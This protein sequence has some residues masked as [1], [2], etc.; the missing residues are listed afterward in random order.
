MYGDTLDFESDSEL[1][2]ADS[3][4][5]WQYGESSKTTFAPFKG[6]VTDTI[7]PYGLGENDHLYLS[8][9]ASQDGPSAVFVLFQHKLD[10]Q[11]A[12]EGA[13]VE[14]SCDSMNWNKVEDTP[15]EVINFYNYPTNQ[16]QST[17][18]DS[19]NMFTGTFN[20]W[21]WSGFQ[22][23]WYLPV[24]QGEENRGADECTWSDYLDG[25]LHV[26]FTFQSDDVETTQAGWMIRQVVVGRM[27]FW[28]SV[29]ETNYHPLTI[30][31]NPT[32]STISIQLP[33]N[34]LKATHTRIYDM[35]GRLVHQHP[36]NPNMDVSH[37]DSG[38]YIVVVETEE[39]NFRGTIQ[40]E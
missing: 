31:P 7:D 24:F 21:K 13:F 26:R 3:G 38:T 22:L 16:Q 19:G 40:K 12:N 11:A 32:T 33:E 29:S 27:D 1:F 10:I 14:V 8:I 30:Y 37:L 25:K 5:L 4:G 34:N 2:A 15:C 18:F 39:G 6:W 23:I 20:E 28:G 9:D 35:T 36:F 17:M